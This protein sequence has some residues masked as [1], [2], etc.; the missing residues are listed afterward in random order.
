MQTFSDEPIT[1][2][3]LIDDIAA[4]KR[5]RFDEL[6]MQTQRDLGLTI[7]EAEVYML[8]KIGNPAFEF[9]IAKDASGTHLLDQG[10]AI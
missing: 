9:A 4:G 7:E 10:H 2:D 1:A 8:D 5:Q 3:T 6:T